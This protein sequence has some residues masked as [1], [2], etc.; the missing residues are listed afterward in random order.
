MQYV[1]VNLHVYIHVYTLYM[2]YIYI[3]DTASI[4]M[5]RYVYMCLYINTHLH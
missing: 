5:K 3:L 1:L 2:F 4:S